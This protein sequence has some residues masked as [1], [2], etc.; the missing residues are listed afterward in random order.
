MAKEVVEQA[1]SA[2]EV[3]EQKVITMLDALEKG[4]VT[5][6]DA[7]V[8]Y[9]PDVADAV[10]GVIRINGLSA[11]M[12]ALIS[13]VLL[14]FVGCFLWKVHKKWLAVDPE[15]LKGVTGFSLLGSIIF[16]GFASAVLI[17]DVF[18]VWNWVAI[19]EPKLALAKQI[20]D[21][22]LNK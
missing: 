10:L 13:F 16:F 8:K 17:T 15:Y 7:A 1:A 14:M 3:L 4:A 20:V 19:F 2:G 12:T 6:G 22:A 18:N 21:A 5:V 11:V 9:A